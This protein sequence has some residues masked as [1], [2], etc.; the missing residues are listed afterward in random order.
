MFTTRGPHPKALQD[1]W[2]ATAAE[3]FPSNPWRLRPG[4]TILRYLELTDTYADC[5]LWMPV[6][7]A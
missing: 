6:E 2:A 3:W 5:E 7:R 4:P 1:T